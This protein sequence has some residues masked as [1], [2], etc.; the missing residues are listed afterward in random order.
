TMKTALGK[1]KFGTLKA[2]L[3]LA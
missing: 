3:S 2:W 1:P